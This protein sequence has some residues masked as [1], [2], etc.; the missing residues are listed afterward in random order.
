MNLLILLSNV[1]PPTDKACTL[2]KHITALSIMLLI[3]I[4]MNCNWESFAICDCPTA[5][6]LEGFTGGITTLGEDA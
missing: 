3:G 6:I 1:S 5:L 2:L 4:I